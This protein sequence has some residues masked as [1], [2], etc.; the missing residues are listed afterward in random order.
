M[1]AVAGQTYELRA[2]GIGHISHS[3]SPYDRTRSSQAP[4]AHVRPRPR[5][6][7]LVSVDIDR[8]RIIERRTA[9]GRRESRGVDLWFVLDGLDRHA[10][11]AAVTQAVSQHADDNPT[12]G[13][14][15]PPRV[16]PPCG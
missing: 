11:A 2:G 1:A 15:T 5:G 16:G 8:D 13:R 6:S 9:W 3:P 14:S 4:L 7:R 10:S 12:C